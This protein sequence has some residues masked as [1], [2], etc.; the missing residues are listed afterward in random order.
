MFAFPRCQGTVII[1]RGKSA[2]LVVSIENAV[3]EERFPTKI[4][5]EKYPGI[6]KQ[7]QVPTISPFGIALSRTTETP[8]KG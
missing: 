4:I 1:T 6:E 3:A 8:S 5:G 7:V 2:D